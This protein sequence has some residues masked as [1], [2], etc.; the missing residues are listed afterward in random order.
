M[1]SPSSSSGLYDGSSAYDPLVSDAHQLGLNVL[2]QSYKVA[3]PPNQALRSWQGV[4]SAAAALPGSLRP[5]NLSTA[6]LHNISGISANVIGSAIKAMLLKVFDGKVD[7]AV[8]EF[9]LAYGTLAQQYQLYYASLEADRLAVE[10]IAALAMERA[11]HKAFLAALRSPRKLERSV[12]R[13]VLERDK[14]LRLELE[15]SAILP[16][17]PR[18]SLDGKDIALEPVGALPTRRWAGEF[19]AA[20]LTD[21]RLPLVVQPPPGMALDDDPSR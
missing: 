21:G 18:V 14:R 9:W 20:E 10:Q 15:F 12:D 11:Q 1:R 7:L 6:V 5:R 13:S 8:Q 17:A 3:L 16:A 2:V 19:N 4:K